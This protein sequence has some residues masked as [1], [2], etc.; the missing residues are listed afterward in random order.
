LTIKTARVDFN[1]KVPY[2][3]QSPLTGIYVLISV[4]DTG[5]GIEDR[6]MDH[7][8]EPF[9]TT[10]GVGEGTGLGLSMVFGFV[11]QSGGHV[12]MESERGKGTTI[13]LY[14]PATESPEKETLAG[15][16]VPKADAKG[17]ETILVVE[18]DRDVRLVTVAMLNNLGYNVLEAEDG[19]S[20]LS[21]LVENFKNIDLVFCDVI[22]PSG[23]SGFDLA[24]ELKRHYQDIK[25][26]M[27]SGYP[28]KVIDRD[29]IDNANIIL[30]G[31]PY[32]KAE[33]AEAVRAVIEQ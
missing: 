33:L 8:F 16:P 11:K 13:N 5:E 23:M 29:G 19:P 24:N 7:V 9:F 31:K 1:G 6:N 25:L 14:F 15:E 30:L 2:D 18:D 26:L 20:A 28:D 17:T 32:R 10:K 21:V 4:S 27:T 22:M 3:N 12:T